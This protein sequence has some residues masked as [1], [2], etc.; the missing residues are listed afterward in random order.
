MNLNVIVR[1]PSVRVVQKKRK[2]LIYTLAFST[3][4]KRKK[5]SK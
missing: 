2:L 3:S 1:T 4:S 5:T